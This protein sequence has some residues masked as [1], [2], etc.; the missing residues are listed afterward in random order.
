MTTTVQ[1]AWVAGILEGEGSFFMLRNHVGGRIYRY[2]RVVVGMSDRDTIERV[3]VL[4]NTKVGSVVN[5]RGNLMIHRAGLTGRRAIR[6]MMTIYPLMSQ[7]RQAAIKKCIDEWRFA[8]DTQARR[9]RACSKA[10]VRR[11]R[12]DAGQFLPLAT[13]STVVE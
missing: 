4:W 11:L 3:A 12:D 6:W 5:K 9:R 13:S 7:R 2:P 8:P 1:I 10:S